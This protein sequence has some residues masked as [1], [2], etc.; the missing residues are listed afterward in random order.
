MVSLDTTPDAALLHEQSYRELGMAGRL[1]IAMELSDFTHALAVA[2]IRR[3]TPNCSEEEA[4][5]R[6]AEVLYGSGD[7]PRE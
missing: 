6:L 5:H 1:R 2:G 4:R 7:L 3:R